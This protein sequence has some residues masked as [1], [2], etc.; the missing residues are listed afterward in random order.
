MCLSATSLAR[1][2]E[3]ATVSDEVRREKRAKEGKAKRGLQC[4]VE[5]IDRLEKWELGLSR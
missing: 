2:D 5:V 1:E 4:E 3:S